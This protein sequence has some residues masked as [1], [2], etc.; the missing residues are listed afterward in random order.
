MSSLDDYNLD[1]PSAAG[2]G[3]EYVSDRVADKWKR[4]ATYFIDYFLLNIFFQIL[5]AFIPQPDYTEVINPND[6]FPVLMSYLGQLLIISSIVSF[7]Y[8]A[9]ME[10]YVGKTIGKMAL[11][12]KVVT[13]DGEKP[14]NIQ[15]LGRTLA[16]FIPFEPFS[17]LGGQGIGW[18]DTLSGTRVIEDR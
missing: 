13:L 14:T 4:L 15:I 9:L 18:H 16:R 11:K 1:D 2:A 8:Y 3:L 6:V 10:I 17:F 7:L 12:T 5:S